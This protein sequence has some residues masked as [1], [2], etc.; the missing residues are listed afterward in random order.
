VLQE[1]PG[2]LMYY[3]DVMMCVEEEP[4]RMLLL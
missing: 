2:L 1:D 3:D 4:I